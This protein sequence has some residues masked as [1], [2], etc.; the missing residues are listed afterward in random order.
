MR[1]LVLNRSFDGA[2][3]DKY[4]FKWSPSNLELQDKVFVRQLFDSE[5]EANA[6]DATAREMALNVING[7]PEITDIWGQYE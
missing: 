3:G 6:Y 7:N 1:T 2:D 5:A 4:A